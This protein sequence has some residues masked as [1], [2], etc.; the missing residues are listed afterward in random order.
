MTKK[1]GL[2]SR[3]FFII[4]LPGEK[5][6]FS[7]RLEEFLCE[8]DP[9]GVDISTLVPYPGSPIF[10][11]PQQWGIKLKGT[12]FPEEFEKYHMTLGLIEKEKRR[13]LVFEHDFLS[14]ETI[15]NEREESFKIILARKNVKNF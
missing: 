7:K 13:P 12:S 9:D 15:Q 14:E 3:L 8:I 1:V 4:G 6:G 10:H 2:K 5:Q 11:D